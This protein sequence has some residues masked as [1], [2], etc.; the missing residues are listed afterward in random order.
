MGIFRLLKFLILCLAGSLKGTLL[1]QKLVEWDNPQ[2]EDKKE[3]RRK[4]PVQIK[5][6]DYGGSRGMKL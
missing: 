4:G 5:F 6:L 2:W 1:L 3:E